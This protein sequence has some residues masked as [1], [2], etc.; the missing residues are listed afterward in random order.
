MHI[1]ALS[2][3]RVFVMLVTD[4]AFPMEID[5]LTSSISQPFAY[6][7]LARSLPNLCQGDWRWSTDRSLRNTELEG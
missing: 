1:F 4:R 7:E 2:K 5:L 3:R 6:H